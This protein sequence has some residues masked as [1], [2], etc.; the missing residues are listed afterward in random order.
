MSYKNVVL[1]DARV[2]SV[3]R[4]HPWIFSGGV[5]RHDRCQDGDLVRV[6]TRKDQFLAVGYFQ[7]ASI[8]V[9]ILSFEDRLIDETF[10]NE[11]IN[12]AIKARAILGLPSEQTNAYRLIHGEGDGIPGLIIDIYND[13]AV[14]QCHAIGI[15]KM[16][17]T[18]AQG[19]FELLAP[20]GLKHIYIKGGNTLPREYA[21]QHV[22]GFLKGHASKT[23]IIENGCLFQV[24]VKEGQKT[25]FFLD[26]RMNR[27][28][29]QEQSKNKS[30]LNLFSY[31]GGFSIYAINGGAKRVVSI[32]ISERA[33]NMCNENVQLSKG[34]RIH[35]AITADVLKYLD[36][37]NEGEFDIIIVDP[38]AFAKSSRKKH[39]AVQAYKR[40][41]AKALKKVRSGGMVFT[42]SCSQV[43]DRP[44]FYNTITAA[45][46]EVKREI[47]VIHTLSQGA[48]HP[49]SI[50][51]PEGQYLKGLV[52]YVR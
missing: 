39:N 10:W 50:Y 11:R 27:K 47:S 13:I 5:I 51:H 37:I 18:I 52:L 38:P 12:A 36:E 2:V 15:H 6:V 8:M 26:Q 4:R 21:S 45:A 9:R 3:K 49:V 40:L 35:E 1:K 31:T 42:F 24:N 14:V 48:D 7:D 46:L 32:D 16:S 20:K 33:I 23:R 17:Q 22:D 28:L 41:N 29:L 19:L 43:I 34:R 30:V 25:G 44:L